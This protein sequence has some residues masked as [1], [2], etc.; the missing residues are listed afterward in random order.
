MSNFINK[1]LIESCKQALAC[2]QLGFCIL[3]ELEM[4]QSNECLHQ[5]FSSY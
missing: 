1:S 2:L 5:I 4:D 3:V